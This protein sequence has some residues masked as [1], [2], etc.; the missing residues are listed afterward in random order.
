MRHKSH[1]EKMVCNTES[2]PGP[3]TTT[4]V[5][6]PMSEPAIPFSRDLSVPYKQQPRQGRMKRQFGRACMAMKIAMVI[7]LLV[8]NASTCSVHYHRHYFAAAYSFLCHP[9][10]GATKFRN[11]NMMREPF[12]SKRTQIYS[13]PQSSS[14]SDFWQSSTSGEQQVNVNVNSSKRKGGPRTKYGKQLQKN[15]QNKKNVKNNWTQSGQYRNRSPRYHQPLRPSSFNE[16]NNDN[17]DRG[18]DDIP[19]TSIDKEYLIWLLHSTSLIL[20]QDLPGLSKSTAK[21]MTENT[22]FDVDDDNGIGISIN[23]NNQRNDTKLNGS[24]TSANSK[25]KRKYSKLPTHFD[26]HEEFIAHAASIMRAWSHWIS[27]QNASGGRGNDIAFGDEF[28]GA[29]TV[30]NILK[31]VMDVLDE[32][33]VMQQDKGSLLLPPSLEWGRKIVELVNISIDAW[34]SSDF[35]RGDGRAVLCA[36]EWLRY[37]QQRQQCQLDFLDGKGNSFS[38]ELAKGGAHTGAFTVVGPNEESYRGLIKAYIRSHESHYLEKAIALVDEME[39][40]SA[41]TLIIGNENANVF[42]LEATKISPTTQTFNSIL[43]GLA[44]CKPCVENAERA[45]ALLQ[46]MVSSSQTQ[47]SNDREIGSL[48]NMASPDSNTFRQVVSAWTKSGSRDAA[49][50]GHRILLNQMMDFS[51]DPDASTFNAIM[52]AYL[53]SN[54]PQKALEVMEVMTRSSTQPDIFSVNLILKAITNNPAMLRRE[55][56][57]A[58]EHLLESMCVDTQSYNIIIDAWGKSHLADAASRAESLLDRMVQKVRR[59]GNTAVAPD[60]YTFTSVLDAIAR[61]ENQKKTR[62]SWAERVFQRMEDMHMEG[63]VPPPTTPV[64]NALLNALATS[65]EDGALL[66]AEA[67]FANMGDLANIRT[68]NI[69]LK[70]YSLF[71]RETSNETNYMCRA[72]HVS[73]PEKAI[74]LLDRMEALSEIQSNSSS[75][76]KK[77]TVAPDKFSYTTV[78]TAYARSSA[79]RKAKKAYEVL[80]RMVDAYENGGNMAAMPGIIAFNGVLNACAHTRSPYEKVEAFTILVSTLLMSQNYTTPDHVTYGTFLKACSRLLPKDEAARK[81]RV[82]EAVFQSCCR[83]GLVDDSVLRQLKHTAPPDLYIAM[84]GKFLNIDG[85]L[86]IPHEWRRNVI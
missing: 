23:M 82:V 13:A 11:L 81:W 77:S 52:T 76:S 50:N 8:C 80:H 34:A 10:G 59:E 9:K 41:Y 47:K 60:E 35:E 39:A 33:E 2:F 19:R 42:I 63:L 75:I 32:W 46:K 26:D 53:R 37:L 27:L 73:Q 78:I 12:L 31:R 79:K 86:D 85:S 4:I 29:K 64:Y 55:K 14:S 40:A 62:G 25:Q 43:Y 58:A 36:E 51:M 5:A 21:D 66:R 30:E 68:Y 70:S 74:K 45:E 3:L 48:G 22:E 56:M 7:I 1:I 20:G 83:E 71:S 54:R 49:E 57:E 61:S 69:M 72:P 18:Q 38:N 17:F 67:L 28:D 6:L 65:N 84:V 44:N 16:D 15:R 24:S